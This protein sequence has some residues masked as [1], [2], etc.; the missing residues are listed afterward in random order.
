MPKYSLH[1]VIDALRTH[2]GLLVLAADALGC[3]R[4]TLYNYAERYPEVAEVLAEERQRFIDL[5][6][7]GL[8]YHL[9]ERSPWAIALV[10]RTL[11]RHRG[12]AER[13]AASTD[14]PESRP[15]TDLS[16]WPQI[17]TVLLQ[18]LEAFPDARWAVVDALKAL[19][20][21]GGTENGHPPSA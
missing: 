15:E 12:Y 17:H 7:Q 14:M 11:G 21:H 5:A 8:Y 4:Q 2:H 3:S 16:E 9:E 6:E 20:P 19:E 1:A 10:L 18:T 13:P